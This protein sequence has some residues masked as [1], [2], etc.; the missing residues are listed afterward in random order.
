MSNHEVEEL[1]SGDDNSQ[2]NNCE[3]QRNNEEQGTNRGEL[4]VYDNDEAY[5][6]DSDKDNK[7][8]NE[9]LDNHGLEGKFFKY[10]FK[11]TYFQI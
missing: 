2:R 7:I 4:N 1:N 11:L 3:S 5:M 9:Y 8:D 6:L 10:K